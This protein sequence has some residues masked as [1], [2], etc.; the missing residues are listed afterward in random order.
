MIYNFL[1]H[2]AFLSDFAHNLRYNEKMMNKIGIGEG[3]NVV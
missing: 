2:L 1:N 3:I